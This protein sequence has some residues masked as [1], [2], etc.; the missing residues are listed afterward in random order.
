MST[1]VPHA[2]DA[3]LV[4]HREHPADPV[5]AHGDGHAT[6]TDDEHGHAAVALGP[7]DWGKW[8]YA[9]VGGAAGLVVLVAF[10]MALN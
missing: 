2:A 1:D 6:V 4:E 10:W 5:T 3:D 9:L 8:L 7:I